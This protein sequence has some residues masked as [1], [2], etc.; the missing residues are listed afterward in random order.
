MIKEVI[1]FSVPLIIGVAIST[2]AISILTPNQAT[3][4]QAVANSLMVLGLIFAIWQIRQ[5]KLEF[6]SDHDWNRRQFAMSEAKSVMAL[7]KAVH[8]EHDKVLKYTDRKLTEPYLVD[9]A[10]GIHDK[11]CEKDDNGALKRDP[12]TARCILSKEGR[13]L[14]SR[15]A[16]PHG[17]NAK[18]AQRVYHD[19]F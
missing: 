15:S 3:Q 5:S 11:I 1:K 6:K 19:N 16:L 10:G 17:R 14:S 13:E 18:A 9:G 4:I 12:D 7:T 2:L 8:K